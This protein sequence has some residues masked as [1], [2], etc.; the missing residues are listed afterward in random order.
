MK[1]AIL[2]ILIENQDKCKV[3]SDGD[4]STEMCVFA[5]DFENVAE[6]I[7]KKITESY[8]SQPSPVMSAEQF[9]L[10]PCDKCLQLTNH[11][12]NIC[13]KCVAK[14]SAEQVDGC[15]S[16]EL[17]S[18]KKRLS[19]QCIKPNDCQFPAA[20][21]SVKADGW[22]RFEDQKP[23]EGQLIL[24]AWDSKGI[25]PEKRR[26]T[27]HD[28]LQ[29]WDGIKWIPVPKWYSPNVNNNNHQ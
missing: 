20:S 17:C 6:Q 10:K 27:G 15:C 1:T 5:Y 16:L 8:A 26:L 13:Q 19:V 7:E 21:P 22:V 11:I 12:G 28:L 14:M 2:K 4:Y 29:N 3:G 9:E 23:D 25:E 24:I 18:S